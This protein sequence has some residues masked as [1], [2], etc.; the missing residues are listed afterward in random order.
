MFR[1]LTYLEGFDE[2]IQSKNGLFNAV[3]VVGN[4]FCY[5]LPELLRGLGVHALE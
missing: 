3:F 1:N 4:V 2:R 5:F